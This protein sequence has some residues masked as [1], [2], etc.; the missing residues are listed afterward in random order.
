MTTP[1]ERLAQLKAEHGGL[2]KVLQK[3]SEYTYLVYDEYGDIS[4]KS[5]EEPTF[6]L[7]DNKIAK[8]KTVDCKIIDENGKGIG[9]FV[10][11]ED[12]HDVCHIKLKTHDVTTINSSTDFLTEVTSSTANVWDIKIKLYKSNLTITKNSKI[13]EK[14]NNNLKFYVTEYKDPHFV[15]EKFFVEGNKL[16]DEGTVKLPHKLKNID[17][18]SIYT[19]KIYDKYVRQN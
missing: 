18:V 1:G 5:T 11:Q 17:N 3:T 9:Q 4:Y 7:G 14:V 12:E 10:I 2:D 19:S 15:L 13:K 6:D 8:L 16:Q